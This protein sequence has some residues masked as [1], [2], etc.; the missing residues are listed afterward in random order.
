MGTGPL[1]GVRSGR[2]MTLTPHPLL[3]LRSKIE[4]RYTSTLPKGLCG[5]WKG[6]TY[7]GSKFWTMISRTKIVYKGGNLVL[8]ISLRCAKLHDQLVDNIFWR[9]LTWLVSATLP[10][11]VKPSRV[12]RHSCT[13]ALQYHEA[14]DLWAT[15][16]LCV[17]NQGTIFLFAP[18]DCLFAVLHNLLQ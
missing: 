13:I 1:L 14:P 12:Y 2:G 8:K 4:Y 18:V 6:E 10:T 17:S 16:K 3:V 15:L 7:L 11:A 9:T 5:L